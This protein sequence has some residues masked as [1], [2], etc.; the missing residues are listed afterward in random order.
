[1]NTFLSFLVGPLGAAF[2]VMDEY[3]FLPSRENFTEFSESMYEAYFLIHGMPAERMY[4]M[5]PGHD[6]DSKEIL[7]V[8]KTE[9]EEFIRAREFLDMVLQDEKMKNA[10]DIEKLNYF[11]SQ[12]SFLF[13]SEGEENEIET[14]KENDE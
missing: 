5:N 2:Q 3:Q 7:T 10:T 4:R 13:P 6:T 9:M 12:F 11:K 1:M 14:N 8:S